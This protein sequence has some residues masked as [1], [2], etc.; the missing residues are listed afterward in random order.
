[1]WL[2]ILFHLY[3]NRNILCVFLCDL[4]SFLLKVMYLLFIIVD[5]CNSSSFILFFA[6]SFSHFLE[7]FYLWFW[8]YLFLVNVH[9]HVYKAM[10]TIFQVDYIYIYTQ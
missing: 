6:L 4:I 9:F 1:M 2:L 7:Q 5:A 3:I 8:D 10:L